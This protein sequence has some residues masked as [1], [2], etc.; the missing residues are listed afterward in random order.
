MKIILLKDVDNLGLEGEIK[1]VKPGYA[2]NFL[3]P[4]GSAIEATK[5]NLKNLEIKLR[6]LEVVRKKRL[7][8][9]D[10]KKKML[11]NL[12]VKIKAKAGD[13]GRLF[14]SITSTNI[15]EEIKKLG[16]DEINKKDIK[17]PHVKEV[18]EYIATVKIL[19]GINAYIK[20]EV[21]GEYVVEE[22]PEKRD[23]KPRRRRTYNRPAEEG[24]EVETEAGKDT[25]ES[26][27]K[28]EE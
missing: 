13:K 4:N 10:E 3:V 17:I 20:F 6:K 12:S 23:Y 14:G 2:R 28:V 19:E 16:F 8:S 9:A 7:A 15:E 11:E 18:G 22:K 26:T 24:T 21:E 1:S 27:D 25:E 5:G